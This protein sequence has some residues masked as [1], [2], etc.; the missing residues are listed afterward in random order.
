MY[1]CYEDSSWTLHNTNEFSSIRNYCS[2][3]LNVIRWRRYCPLHT[4]CYRCFRINRDICDNNL[5]NCT[6][7][8]VNT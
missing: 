8:M 3:G 5:S 1:G 6:E 7:R 4:S 2:D